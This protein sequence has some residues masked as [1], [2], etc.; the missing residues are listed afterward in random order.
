M[1]YENSTAFGG[2]ISS[3]FTYREN[4]TSVS[5]SLVDRKDGVRVFVSVAAK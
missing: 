2:G 5:V 1:M 4:G 3:A